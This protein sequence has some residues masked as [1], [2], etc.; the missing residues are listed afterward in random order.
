MVKSQVGFFV[1]GPDASLIVNSGATLYVKGIFGN[2]DCD[3]INKVRISGVV[4]CSG[5]ILNNDSMVWQ[6][7]QPGARE[8]LLVIENL[9]ADTFFIEGTSKTV[10]RTMTVN[11][12]VVLK[13]SIVLQDTLRFISGYV[14]LNNHTVF[15]QEPVGIPAVMHRP[16]IKG[17]GGA[18]GFR[19]ANLSDTGSIHYTGVAAATSGMNFGNLGLKV[20][21]PINVG[22]SVAVVRKHLLQY[23][24]GKSGIALCFDLQG[25]ALTNQDTLLVNYATNHFSSL[26]TGLITPSALTVFVSSK[27]D[28]WWHPLPLQ[29]NSQRAIGTLTSGTLIA[30]MHTMTTPLAQISPTL[31]RVTIGDPLCGSFASG[32]SSPDTLN[33]CPGANY[34]LQAGLISPVPNTPLRYQWLTPQAAYASTFVTSATAAY[35][36]ITVDIVD[37]RGCK[38]MDSCVVAPVA[39]LPQIQYFNHLNSCW[40]DSTL[41]KDSVTIASGSYTRTVHTSDNQFAF[42]LSNYFKMNF[43]SAGTYTVQLKAI[44]N[45]G[46][47]TV[48][49]RTNVI[50]YSPPLPV[51][52]A[53]INCSNHQVVLSSLS[54]SAHPSLNITNQ[55]WRIQNTSYQGS[56]VAI[57]TPA[58]GSYSY[59]LKI[60]DNAGCKDSLISYFAVPNNNTLS[61]QVFNR[62]EGDTTLIKFNGTCAYNPCQ[63]KWKPGDGSLDSGIVVSRVYVVPGQKVLHL[64]VK[65]QQGCTDSVQQIVMINSRPTATVV[66]FTSVCEGQPIAVTVSASVPQGQVAVYQWNGIIGPPVLNFTSTAGYYSHNLKVISD[67]GCVYHSSH[68]YTIWPQPT[69]DFISSNVCLNDSSHFIHTGSLG[70]QQYQWWYGNANNSVWL[71]TF[72]DH[73]LYPAS[74]N[75]SVKQ[76]VKNQYGCIDSV[77]KPVSVYAL[78]TVSLGGTITTCGN[79][80]TLSAAN[81]NATYSWW[82]LFSQT[83]TVAVL[84]TGWVK[85]NVTNAQGC[86]AKDSAY[87]LLNANYHPDLG[88]DRTSCGSMTLQLNNPATT[89]SWNTGATT[90]AIAVS[91]S[92]LYFLSATDQNGCQGVDS[93]NVQINAPASIKLPND[94]ALCFKKEGLTITAQTNAPLVSWKDLTIGATRTILATGDY[95]AMALLNNGCKA[96]DTIRVLYKETPKIALEDNYSS[97]SPVLVNLGIT[98]AAITWSDGSNLPWLMVATTANYSV[99]AT[100]SLTG[101]SSSHFFSVDIHPSPPLELGTDTTLCSNSGFWL[102]TRNYTDAVDWIDGVKT[103][104]RYVTL[105]GIYAA[106]VTNNYGCQSYDQVVVNTRYVPDLQVGPSLQYRCGNN[107]LLLSANLLCDWWFNDHFIE[108]NEELVVYSPGVYV[109]SHSVN[110][111]Q[112]TQVIEVVQTNDSLTADF[113]V[114]TRDTINQPVQFVCLTDPLPKKVEWDFGDGQKSRDIHPIHS[115]I[116]PHNY[117]VALT[118]F[119][120]QCQATEKKTLQAL[121]RK[122]RRQENQDGLEIKQALVFPVPVSNGCTIAI[123]LSQLA[124][125]DVRI[126]DALGR[127]LRIFVPQWSDQFCE[128]LDTSLYSKGVYTCLIRVQNQNG[129][130]L[131]KKPIVVQ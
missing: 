106:T 86:H 31:F 88:P 18:S 77:L 5:A 13:Q 79:Q 17:E 34:T 22:D 67:S 116:L 59:A 73:Y 101:C 30:A 36:K 33:L 49:I 56:V 28:L 111:C 113:L 42:N 87:V 29:S 131:L 130:Y 16:W 37:V 27:Q 21:G 26:P 12:T 125:V 108:R 103:P 104:D 35:Q 93:V 64:F 9:N 82:P 45:Y 81:A 51:A 90:P 114:A 99:T 1:N 120:D 60:I 100:N 75:Y 54:S 11:S 15:L 7:T 112:A 84:S 107:P 32:L 122:A 74:G 118:V 95:V 2:V 24:A 121:F 47:E 96:F 119:N 46:C 127:C 129:Y 110:G 71:T 40:G 65:G 6:P 102:S 97:C 89:Y 63:I 48:A 39:P 115:Y 20:K 117:T 76:R 62:C 38:T 72:V 23:L 109:A 44:S 41:F 3:P 92:G 53:S 57:T 68:N 14:Y 58:P 4:N 69:A 61:A 105:P 19:T 123:Q 124:E 43:I 66:G 25:K 50:V 8:A 94:T 80:Y 52:G 55:Q 10:F 126:Y 70:Q 98:N 85:V 91:N 128:S 83:P 78:P